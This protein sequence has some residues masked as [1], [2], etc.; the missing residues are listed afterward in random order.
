MF[1][2]E[3]SEGQFI[4]GERINYVWITNRKVKFSISGD[5]ETLFI[6]DKVN[7]KSFL[8][9]LQALNTSITDVAARHHHINNPDTKY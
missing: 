7:E 3:F 4:D 8:N 2:I 9:Q 6:V 5:N 1:L